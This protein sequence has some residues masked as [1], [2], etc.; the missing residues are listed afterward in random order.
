MRGPTYD[1]GQWRRAVVKHGIGVSQVNL[2]NCFRHLEKLVSPFI[3]HTSFILDDM[4][5]AALS[6]NSSD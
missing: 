6:N 3:F 5:L 2:S 1:P 4:K